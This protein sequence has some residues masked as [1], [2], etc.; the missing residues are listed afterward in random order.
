MLRKILGR[1]SKNTEGE[2][3]DPK[4]VEKIAKMNLNDMRSYVKGGK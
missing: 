1:R 2:S 3:V 4:V